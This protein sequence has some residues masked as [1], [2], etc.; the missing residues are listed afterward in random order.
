MLGGV[1]APIVS[2]S[3]NVHSIYVN[4]IG[5]YSKFG[6]HQWGHPLPMCIQLYV[7]T[8]GTYSILG[9]SNNKAHLLPMCTQLAC[10]H[11]KLLLSPMG[12]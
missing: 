6:E 10:V 2:Y 8:I 3:P 12:I 11:K 7:N 9:S 1:R 4:T 5:T